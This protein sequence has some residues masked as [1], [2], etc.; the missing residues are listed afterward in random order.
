[1]RKLI[2]NKVLGG[3]LLI[4]GTTLGAGM[5]AF[6]TATSFGGFVPATLLFLLIWAVMLASSF[7][8]LDVN[9][10]L[11][12]QTNMITMAEQTLGLWGKLLAWVVYLLLLYSL[13]AAYIAGCSPLF[14][15][16]IET[17]TGYTLPNQVANFI[18]PLAF[19]GFIYAGVRG[20][21]LA[22]RILMIGLVFA[23]FFLVFFVPDQVEASR[24]EHL[25]WP[26]ITVAIPV[27]ITAFGYHIVIPSLSTYMA[28]D[29]K[30]MT[31]AILIGSIIP[32]LVYLL[33]QVLVL[34]AVPLES[35]IEAYQK[36]AT[37][38][39]PLAKALQNPLVSVA[40]KLFAFFA[41]V[42]SFVGV[43]LSLSDFLTDGFK[44][45]RNHSGKIL[46]ILLTF[47]PPLF[48]V[49]TYQRGFYVALQY[50]GAF[51]AILL[52]FL[53]AAMAWKLKKYKTT[54]GRFVLILLCLVAIGVV[55]LDFLEEGGKLKFLTSKYQ[56]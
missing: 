38:T 11:K 55:A 2:T 46:A 47:L 26:A 45:K 16:A 31:K 29:R 56:K 17:L 23:Y 39:Q 51:V 15:D 4:S 32:I 6:P 48:F 35:L 52:V 41:I 40:A 42:T 18:L 22:N 49:F 37:A 30:K 36:G 9:L 19:G 5:L 27:V 20:V 43:T 33:W 53:P 34:G 3:V 10:S 44:I 24:L 50:A 14:V 28:R 13:T 8:F 25:D 54:S 1:M 12:G 21:D 7:C